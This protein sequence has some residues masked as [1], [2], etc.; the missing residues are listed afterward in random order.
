MAAEKATLISIR[1]AAPDGSPSR[2]VYLG[3]V[4]K[5]GVARAAATGYEDSAVKKQRGAPAETTESHRTGR[6][7]PARGR[8]EHLTGGE[9]T[10]A[11]ASG[12]VIPAG[13]QDAA[14]GKQDRSARGGAIERARRTEGAGSKPTA[15]RWSSATRMKAPMAP[16]AW[17]ARSTWKIPTATST[18]TSTTIRPTGKRTS[19]AP[20][21]RSS[22]RRTANSPTSSPPWEPAGPLPVPPAACAAIS[23]K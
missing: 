9:I 18:P 17:S 13:E 6:A 7:E 19:K 16:S 10:A 5:P 8:I 14:V 2:L 3:G 23:P 15:P 12:D 22:T 11:L 4:E 1:R 21:P 20:A